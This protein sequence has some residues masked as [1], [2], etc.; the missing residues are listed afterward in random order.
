MG[1]LMKRHLLLP[2][3]FYV[4]YMW[5]LI[6]N[7]FRVRVKALKDKRVKL[8]QYK[9]NS[10]EIPDDVVVVANH[11][12]NQFQVPML[13]FVVCG[14]VLGLGLENQY[15]VALAWAFVGSRLGHTYEHLTKNRP[16]IR[17]YWYTAGWLIIMALWIQLFY[18]AGPP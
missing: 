1:L 8:S 11:F 14:I 13:F 5:L 3:I 12:N 7:T 6:L 9:A 17:G 15:T 18:L 10:G 2:M 4:F 16:M